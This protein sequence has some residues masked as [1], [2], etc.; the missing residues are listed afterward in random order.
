MNEVRAW[1]TLGHG[2]V[3]AVRWYVS[4]APEPIRDLGLVGVGANR[5]EG[6]CVERRDLAS[7]NKGRFPMS[8]VVMQ[9]G[10]GEG[11]LQKWDW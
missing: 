5:G 7:W 3:L 9:S 2:T 6:I 11:S 1:R 8:L 4:R 10:G